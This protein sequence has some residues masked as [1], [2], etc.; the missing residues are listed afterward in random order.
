MFSKC[1]HQCLQS[2]NNRC[3]HTCQWFLHSTFILTV[4]KYKPQKM[5]Q[6]IHLLLLNSLCNIPRYQTQTRLKEFTLTAF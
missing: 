3:Q 4:Q 6:I 2:H 1:S 5:L